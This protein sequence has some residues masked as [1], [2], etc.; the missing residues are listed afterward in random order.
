MESRH[1]VIVVEYL[2]S[3]LGHTESEGEIA[4]ITIRPDRGSFR[5]HN[6]ALPI[7]QAKRL[8]E[9]LQ[10]ILVP[11]TLAVCV[12]LNGCSTRVEV[13]REQLAHPLRVIPSW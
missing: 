11:A 13:T 7:A 8:L 4:I 2:N 9:D 5:P 12:L 10:R 1:L 3:S 6:V